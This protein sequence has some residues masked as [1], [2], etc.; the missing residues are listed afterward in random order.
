MIVLVCGYPGV[1]KTT[2]AN[3]LK[4]LINGVVLSTDKIRKE[5]ID[6]PTYSEQ[7]KKLIYNVLILLAKYLHNAGINCILDA[8]FNSQKTRENIKKRLDLTYNQFKII[9]CICPEKI[10]ISRL[11]NRKKGYSDADESI[12]KLIKAKYEPIEEKHITVDTSQPLRKI[13]TEIK[14]KI[15]NES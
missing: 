5:L 13:I 15:K 11:K 1:G 2:I 14:D 12:Y 8:T 9:E 6:K 10:I 7:E 3:E 4:S